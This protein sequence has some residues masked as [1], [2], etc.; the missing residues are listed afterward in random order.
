VEDQH[1]ITRTLA[2]LA[3]GRD[4]AEPPGS[5]ADRIV[6]FLSAPSRRGLAAFETDAL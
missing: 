4:P 1:R 6:A 2:A 3:S 5:A